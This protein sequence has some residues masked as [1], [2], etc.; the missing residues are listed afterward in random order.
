MFF[1]ELVAGL[2]LVAVVL[3]DVFETV[4]VP[5]RTDS[6]WRLA[7]PVIVA[8]YVVEEASTADGIRVAVNVAAL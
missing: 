3:Y 1:V 2:M 6:K 4:V 7:P 8:V 5:R